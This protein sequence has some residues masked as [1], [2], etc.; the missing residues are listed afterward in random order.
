M[1]ACET[2]ASRVLE[3]SAFA[4]RSATAGRGTGIASSVVWSLMV[5]RGER[6]CCCEVDF[7]S[8][9]GRLLECAN[10]P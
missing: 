7:M 6:S 9:R 5:R 3:P 4:A 1:V 8:M 10:F 2:A